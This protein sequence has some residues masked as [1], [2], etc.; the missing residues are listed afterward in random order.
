MQELL[1]FSPAYTIVGIYRLLTDAILRQKVWDKLRHGFTRGVIVGGVWAVGTFGIQRTIVR[2]FLINSPRI[3]GLSHEDIFGYKINVATYATCL[4]LSSQIQSIIQFFVGK[5]LRIARDRAWEHTLVS[6]G[7]APEFWGP[8]VEEWQV[9]PKVGVTPQAKWE[10]WITSSIGRLII[11]KAVLIPLNFYPGVGL[12]ASSALKAI[13]TARFL[14][15][16]YFESK[17][18]TPHEIALFMAERKWD[19]YAFGFAAALL[20]SIPLTGL[21]FTISN[22]IGACMWAFDLEKRQHLFR[23]GKLP[24]VEPPRIVPESGSLPPRTKGRDDQ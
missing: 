14:H 12:V 6:R 8:Y 7:K 15:K 11:R 2:I 13:G 10:K 24:P 1:L 4:F 19:Y 23:D 9:P 18:M 17:K 16:P 22:R 21:F 3:T 20:E 5:N